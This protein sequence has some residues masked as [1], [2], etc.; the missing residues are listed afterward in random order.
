MT[1]DLEDPEVDVTCLGKEGNAAGDAG[2]KNEGKY[3]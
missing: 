1:F 3:E 2:A